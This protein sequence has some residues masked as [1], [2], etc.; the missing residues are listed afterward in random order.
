MELEKI[1]LSKMQ[2]VQSINLRPADNGGCTLSYSI[3]TPSAKNNQSSYDEHNEVFA[4]NEIEEA[5]DRIKEL[6]RANLQ[7]KKPI[8]NAGKEVSAKG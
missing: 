8:M 5:L 6:Y 4:D 1:K 3:Y 7:A 2:E